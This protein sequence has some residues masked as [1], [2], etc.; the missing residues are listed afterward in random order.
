MSASPPCDGGAVKDASGHVK[1]PASGSCPI[2]SGLASLHFGTVADALT[3]AGETTSSVVALV[4]DD[5]FALDH[6][7]ARTLN[8]GLP[9]LG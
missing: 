4:L 1:K 6:R 8:R 7:P 3:V 5:E 2:C 9:L